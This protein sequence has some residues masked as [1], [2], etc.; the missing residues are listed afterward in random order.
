MNNLKI[1]TKINLLA[2]FLI[3]VMIVMGLTALR[4][5]GA[6]NTAEIDALHRAATMTSTVDTARLAQVEFKKQIQEWK[7]IL[8]RGTDAETLEKYTNA[9]KKEADA[10]QAALL[11]LKDLFASMKLDP[12]LVSD[13]MKAHEELGVKYLEALKQYDIEDK[14]SAHEVDGLV[15]GMDRA[16]TEKFDQIV[17]Y[18]MDQATLAN[19]KAESEA[20]A[21]YNAVKMWLIAEL[22]FGIVIGVIVTLW[23]ERVITGP[24]N[25]AL[26]VA[27]TVASGDLSARV[28]ITGNDEAGQ[29]LRALKDMNDS[30][31]RI[32]GEVRVGTDT[33]ATASRQIASGNMDL[34]AR[35]ES[36]AG[37]LEETASSMEELTSTVKQNADNARQANQLAVSAS[38]VAVKGGAVVAKVVDTMGSINASSKK[39]VDI[40]SV[41]DGIAFQTN[42]LAL[43]AAVEAARAGEQGR[44]FAV[45]AAE[46]RNLAQRSA[47]AAKEIKA[48][49][50]DSV[51]KVDAGAKLVD[52]AGATM[53]EVVDSI[54]RVTDIMG[55]ITAASQEQTAGIEQVNQAITQMDDATQ[56]NA[57]LVEEA[58][59]AAQS[60]QSQSAKLLQVV[61]VF[62]LTGEGGAAKLAAPAK[63]ITSSS[64]SS[65]S[66]SSP[67]ALPGKVA[68][69]GNAIAAPVPKLD[70]K[71]KIA[72]SSKEDDWEEF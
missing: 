37:A 41:I 28:H 69:K 33:I 16:P 61:S 65:S 39:I 46:V 59:A 29:L 34:S 50:G 20:A 10:S 31:V 42:I 71:L 21:N 22:F 25:D 14:K 6:S 8:L 30:L 49:I 57:A 13:A 70:K 35:T 38:E 7:N 47:S 48:L 60:M 4:T 19:N 58:A 9:F 43:N 62:K 3:A 56:Q 5:H 24:L 1:G 68:S 17:A 72:H 2:G 32:V 26:A 18:V 40:I 36:Q 63:R 45:V 12:Q 53:Q 15:K 67:K 55:E 23:L 64:P 11:K 66:G 54:R 27:Q 44:G 51:E 52:Q